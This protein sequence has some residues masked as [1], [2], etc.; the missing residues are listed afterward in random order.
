MANDVIYLFMYGSADTNEMGG[1]SCVEAPY[2]IAAEAYQY[3]LPELPVDGY[4]A[5]DYYTDGEM[6]WKWCIAE[7]YCKLYKVCFND[8]GEIEYELETEFPMTEFD[9]N[10][11]DHF[12]HRF[13]ILGNF[14]ICLA[15]TDDMELS[16][17]TYDMEYD[18]AEV[19][20][21]D[22]EHTAINVL[23][24]MPYTDETVLVA[25]SP[26]MENT[27]EVI[28]YELDP[29]E[30]EL[31][32]LVTLPMGG[33]SPATFGYVYDRENDM[34][35]F[36]MEGVLYRIS[37]LDPDSLEV[38]YD[39]G[40]LYTGS[41]ILS[42]SHAAAIT[43]DGHY[44]VSNGETILAC[45]IS[46][47]AGSADTGANLK[48]LGPEQEYLWDAAGTYV[49]DAPGSNVSIYNPAEQ[50][51]DLTGTLASKS[52][53]YDIYILRVDSSEYDS[54]Y[55]RGYLLP[56]ENGEITEFVDGMYPNIREMAV[57]DGSVVALP[58]SITSPVI[59]YDPEVLE[60]LGYT[61][62]GFAVHLARLYGIPVPAARAAGGYGLYS[63]PGGHLGGSESAKRSQ[64][65]G[66]RRVHG[67]AE[68]R[69]DV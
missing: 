29:A 62:G 47:D 61:A 9:D 30:E 49:Q 41:N 38:V 39:L 65:C 42:A 14:F 22:D 31:T 59:T 1:Y 58:L 43:S 52:D 28:L 21:F 15:D 57:K 54:M 33:Y 2:N 63:V 16:L 51:F 37:G 35:N 53:A 19:Y 32:E 5:F 6:I 45:D 46:G 7:D 56:M 44:I 66:K 23:G 4:G 64:A 25:S 69:T 60:A 34:L 12:W 8:A 20:E 3:P 40:Y 67:S 68:W 18:D 10:E 26:A 55:Q 27:G 48:I 17:V 36:M 13:M 24:M 50:E 11:I